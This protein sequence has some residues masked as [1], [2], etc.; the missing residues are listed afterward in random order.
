MK[1]GREMVDKCELV[2]VFILSIAGKKFI[3]KTPK[4]ETSDH[5]TRGRGRPR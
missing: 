5:A 1:F 3:N 2:I 4:L